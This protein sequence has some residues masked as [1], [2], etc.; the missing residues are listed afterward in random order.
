MRTL[1]LRIQPVEGEALDSWLEA[2]C[3]RMHATWERSVGQHRTSPGLY[4]EVVQRHP[5]RSHSPGE[6]GLAETAT[7]VGASVLQSMTL[8]PV[9][10]I[11]MAQ[12]TLPRSSISSMLWLNPGRRS[13]FCPECLRENGGRWY[14]CW[15]LRWAFAC[16]RHACLLV[17]NCPDCGRPQRTEP[18]PANLVP[19]PIGCTRKLVGTHGRDI[20]RCCGSLGESSSIALPWEHPTLSAQREYSRHW[21]TVPWLTESTR[22]RRSGC[23]THRRSSRIGQSDS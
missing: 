17:D 10:R 7:G 4:P 15:R 9:E 20:R 2:L 23:C 12:A 5:D 8:D 21:P 6:V 16:L 1:P 3:V 22:P 19:T 13:R 18:T 11:V 14:L